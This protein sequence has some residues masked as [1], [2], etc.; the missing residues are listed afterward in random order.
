[1]KFNLLFLVI[2]CCLCSHAKTTDSSKNTENIITGDVSLK[3]QFIHKALNYSDNNPAM[4]ASFLFNLGD[5]AKIGFWGSN[6]SNLSAVD[7]NF[8]FKFLGKI[9]FDLANS[10]HLQLIISDDHFYKSSTRNGQ[11]VGFDIKYQQHLV[12]LEWQSNF[13]GTKSSA[14]YLRYGRIFDFKKIFKLGG[15]GGYTNSHSGAINSY[16][17]L[18]A[19]IQY[20]INNFSLV[21]LG[22]TFNSHNSQFG[23]KGDPAYYLALTLDY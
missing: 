12:F 20:T 21:E 18:K 17:D 10:N 19:I 8:W 23:A 3:S 22:A 2:I 4:S 7:D 6:I 13:E 5:T 15:F 11:G 14:E 1:M 9:D 16:F